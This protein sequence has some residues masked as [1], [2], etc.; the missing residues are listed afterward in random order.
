MIILSKKGRNRDSYRLR[1][2]IETP[3]TKIYFFRPKRYTIAK[4]SNATKTKDT[5]A[6]HS[7]GITTPDLLP[8]EKPKKRLN[9][10]PTKP[11]A[12][13]APINC[14]NSINMSFIARNLLDFEMDTPLRNKIA[15][16]RHAV[17]K[18]QVTQMQCLP[19]FFC[20]LKVEVEA[21]LHRFVN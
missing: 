4:H 14:S 12:Q 19:V 11:K 16:S 2:T 6:S 9:T 18:K 15:E 20:E 13:T 10:Q 1:Q 8:S 5:P 17:N 3:S 7:V 21:F